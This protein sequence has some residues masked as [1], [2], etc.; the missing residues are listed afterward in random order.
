MEGEGGGIVAVVWIAL[1]AVILAAVLFLLF[2]PRRRWTLIYSESGSHTET[3]DRLDAYL[4]SH[5][6]ASR[7]DR[8]RGIA[9]LY[10]P[11]ADAGQAKALFE[12]FRKENL[13]R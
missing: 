13:T 12:A 8:D 5:G 3:A 6:V 7:L 10:V 9:R 11:E 1:A 4:H 2:R